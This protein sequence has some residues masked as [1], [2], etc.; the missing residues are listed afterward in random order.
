M[1]QL[2]IECGLSNRTGDCYFSFTMSRRTLSGVGVQ[3]PISQRSTTTGRSLVLRVISALN[4]FAG[5]AHQCHLSCQ[6]T[7]HACAVLGGEFR[8]GLGR[9]LAFS[10]LCIRQRSSRS[11]FSLRKSQGWV[12]LQSRHKRR[13]LRRAHRG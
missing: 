4:N 8:G 5:M 7:L 6:V 13:A 11:C 1:S 9:E 3:V 12:N 2:G 10:T